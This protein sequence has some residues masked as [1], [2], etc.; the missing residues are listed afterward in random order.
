[1][2]RNFLLKHILWAPLFLVGFLALL[3][4]IRFRL[5][6]RCGIAVGAAGDMA[7]SGED[8]QASLRPPLPMAYIPGLYELTTTGH[9]LDAPAGGALLYFDQGEGYS[10]HATRPLE[11]L[12]GEPATVR[13]LLSR[14]TFAIRFDPSVGP[15]SLSAGQI[16]IRRITRAEIMYTAGQRYRSRYPTDIRSLIGYGRIAWQV[17]RQRGIRYLI[18]VVA[19]EMLAEA[20]GRAEEYGAWIKRHDAPDRDTLREARRRGEALPVQPLMSVV[21]PTY[22]S[23]IE[24]LKEM[25]ESV[26][27]QTYENWELC[28]ADDASPDP[29][30]V[31]SIRQFAASDP[32]I[33]LVVREQNGHIS[34]A[35]NSAL[36]LAT[37]EWVVL[38]DHDDLLPPH[39][40]YCVVR[41]I[42]ERPQAKIIFSDEDKITEAGARQDPYMKGEFDNYLFYGHNMVSHLGVYR[43]DMVEA[44]GGLRPGY[45]GSQDYDLAL[46]VSERCDASEIVH[47]PHVLYHW[48][49]TEGSTAVSAG[50]KSYAEEAARRAINDHFQRTGRPY[51]SLPGRAPGNHRIEIVPEAVD[52]SRKLSVIILTR[53]GHDLLV[54]CISSFEAALG[55]GRVHDLVVVDHQSDDPAVRSYLDAVAR[56]T[57][58]VTVLDY[59]GDF[60]F[61]A[62]NN[63]AAAEAGGDILCFL[64][65]D[66]VFLTED[67]P[68]RTKAHFA[69]SEIGVVGARMLYPDMTVQHFGIH[70]GKG[71]HRVAVHAHHGLR[72][73][74]PGNMSRAWLTQQFAAVTG[75]CLSIDAAL[76]RAVGGFDEDLPVAYNDVD[77]CLAVRRAGRKVI[78]DADIR[79]IHKESKSRGRDITDEKRQRLDRDAAALHEKWGDFLTTDPF[80]S[81]NLDHLG[82]TIRFAM[83][84]APP[85]AWE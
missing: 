42:N 63:L 3:V 19:D 39:A 35:T 51:R 12:T 29:R 32:R 18:E 83:P 65:N 62:M 22:N 82:A 73:A 48:R 61:S 49:L 70:T 84:P 75:A 55:S 41:T 2:K 78:C 33:K 16:R 34:R 11:G 46:R 56:R 60:N 80:L 38:L 30:V 4:P 14:P 5:I 10:E 85:R 79:L 44:V 47:I 21:V 23:K 45:E 27:A 13:I 6:P 52:G 59:R 24:L 81:P 71:E 7:W 54:D 69:I 15:G 57:G 67:W 36:E 8:P 1:M 40:L 17:V 50:Q 43:R 58:R 77:L 28:I 66:T 68:E 72:D 53:N 25:I 64:N 20:R 26:R 37:G 74:H 9:R 76:F 31:K